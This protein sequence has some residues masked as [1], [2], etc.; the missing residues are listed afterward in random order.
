MHVSSI[1]EDPNADI[2]NVSLEQTVLV[3]FFLET[4]A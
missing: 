2:E 4:I 3:R 1:L